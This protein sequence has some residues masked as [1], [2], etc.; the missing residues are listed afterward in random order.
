[1]TIS[2]IIARAAARLAAHRGENSRLDAEVLLCHVLN[3]DRA[4]LLAHH[5]DTIGS[6]EQRYYDLLLDR[7]A[8][9][10]PLQYITAKQEF[11]GIGFLVTPD[12]LIPRPETELVVERALAAAGAA[13]TP[14]IVDLCTGSGC[15]AVSLAR[16]LASARVYAVD[17]SPEA[18]AVART[19]SLRNGVDGRIG[20]LTG[21]LFGPLGFAVADG[22]VDVVTANPPYVR[23]GDLP[24]LQPE[25]R[26]FEPEI[27]LVSG[28]EGT[29]VAERILR[30]TPRFLRSGGTLIMEFGMGQAGA[31]QAIAAD[32][33]AYGTTEVLRDLAGID[34]VIITKKK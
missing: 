8:V 18:L 26:D 5:P 9:R 12:V 4:W 32:T 24:A 15:I 14:V 23:S 29:E 28:P 11:W 31:L 2:E 30:E 1:M 17:R 19:N 20:F 27:A 25:V 6:E 7:R 13:K 33:G 3:R 22:S 34:R 21:D 16:E 10:E